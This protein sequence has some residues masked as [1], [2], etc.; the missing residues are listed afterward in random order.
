M[1]ITLKEMIPAVRRLKPARHRLEMLPKGNGLTVIDDAYNSNPEGAAAALEALSMFVGTKVI[2]TPGMVELGEKEEA[3]NRVFGEKIA[4]VCDYTAL[5]GEKQT[6][7]ILAGIMEAGY[8]N[9][10]VKVFPSFNQA[11]Q[12]ALSV[13]EGEKVILLENDLPD[14]YS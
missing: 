12:W 9:E 3:E 11:Y 1:G 13:G 14:N 5:V 2:I 8:D 10:R 4:K 6:R 7:P